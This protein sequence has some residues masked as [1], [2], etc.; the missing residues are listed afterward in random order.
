MIKKIERYQSQDG[1]EFNA[2]HKAVQHEKVCLENFIGKLLD[3]TNVGPGEKLKI[4]G[5]LVPDV[6]EVNN[7]VTGRALA[8]GHIEC[9]HGLL[10]NYM[11]AVQVLVEPERLEEQQ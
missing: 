5:L 6:V 1:T 10:R 8:L 4:M 3:K 11:Q 7:R 2:F 9:F